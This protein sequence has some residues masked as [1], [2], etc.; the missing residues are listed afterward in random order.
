MLF[1][2]EKEKVK[3]KKK[4]KEQEKKKKQE[5]DREKVK[6]KEKAKEAAAQDC[7]SCGAQGTCMATREG[8]DRVSASRPSRPMN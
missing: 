4:D 1:R 2:S 6:K 8:S 5:N 7:P 3:K